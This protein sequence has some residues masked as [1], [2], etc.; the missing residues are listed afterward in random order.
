[1]EEK[2]AILRSKVEGPCL[3]PLNELEENI[4][5]KTKKGVTEVEFD[6]CGYSD[7]IE[8]YYEIELRDFYGH[9]G[10][11]NE[12]KNLLN[13]EDEEYD[14]LCNTRPI[15][16]VTATK[17]IVL[18]SFYEYHK[19]LPYADFW[20]YLLD[21]QFYELTNGSNHTLYDEEDIV[22]EDKESHAEHAELFSLLKRILFK[23]INQHPHFKGEPNHEIDFYVSW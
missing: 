3:V 7:L 11:N 1:M 13:L 22:H 5:Y 8:K 19:T 15:D 23:E 17:V 9:F 12:I 18:G 10:K 6:Y 4:T 14:K 21:S 16:S 2:L 20:H